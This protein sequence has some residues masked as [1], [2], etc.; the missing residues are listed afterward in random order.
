MKERLSELGVPVVTGSPFG[1]IDLNATI[2]AGALRACG[3][4]ATT[5]T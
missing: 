4:M 2:P 5:A 3:S 1:H